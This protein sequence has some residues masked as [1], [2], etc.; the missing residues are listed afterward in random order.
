MFSVKEIFATVQGEGSKAGNPS[1]FVRFAGCNLWSG[2]EKLR[3]KAK[4]HCGLWCDTDFVKG[5]K[6]SEED[7][8][9]A[10]HSLSSQWKEKSVVFTGGEP[11]LQLKKKKGKSLVG[12]LFSDGFSVCIETNGTISNEVSD[13]IL[14]HPKG[15]ITVSPKPLMNF[16]SDIEHILLREGTDL[17][18]IIPTSFNL[19]KLRQWSFEHFYLQPMDVQ[20][21]TIGNV[22]VEK[23]VNLCYKFGYKLSVQTHKFIGME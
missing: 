10:I 18:I 6:Y 13:Y 21:G 3:E 20:D 5:T 19:K 12:K 2:L 7:L 4:G 15:H 17:K 1:I 11:L 22:N 23:T 9:S 14:V 8:I 16:T